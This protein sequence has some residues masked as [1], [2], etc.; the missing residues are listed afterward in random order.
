M[1]HSR[2]CW[3]STPVSSRKQKL[4]VEIYDVDHF[5]FYFIQHLQPQS[6]GLTPN[7]PDGWRHM[8]AAAW[9]RSARPCGLVSRQLGLSGG[10]RGPSGGR[11]AR[12]LVPSEWVAGVENISR[13]RNRLGGVGAGESQPWLNNDPTL[14]FLVSASAGWGRGGQ[15]HTADAGVWWWTHTHTILED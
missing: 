13:C 6:G 7:R 3:N 10:W 5:Y 12:P 4:Q 2:F 14:G 11:G 1:P 15:T 8:R 9:L